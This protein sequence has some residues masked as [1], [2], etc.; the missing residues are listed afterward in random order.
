MSHSNPSELFS[1]KIMVEN[2]RAKNLKWA[3]LRSFRFQIVAFSKHRKISRKQ[4]RK[5]PFL[6][7]GA[8]EEKYPTLIVGS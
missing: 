4:N 6:L 2:L 1:S 8:F 5:G 7:V 3:T